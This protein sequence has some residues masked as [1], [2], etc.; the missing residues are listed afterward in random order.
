M[1]KKINIKNK[2]DKYFIS[3]LILA[4]ANKY[5][6]KPINAKELLRIKDAQSP[7]PEIVPNKGPKALSM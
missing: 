5:Q 4:I 1:R 3:K 2:I 7:I 6:P